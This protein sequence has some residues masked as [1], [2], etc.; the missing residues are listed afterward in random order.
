MK[1]LMKSSEAEALKH[2]LDRKLSLT[3][4]IMDQSP[5]IQR[6]SRMTP[7]EIEKLPETERE[8]LREETLKVINGAIVQADAQVFGKRDRAARTCSQAP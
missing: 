2:K 3:L 6:L 1:K 5:T 7:E 8:K 4:N